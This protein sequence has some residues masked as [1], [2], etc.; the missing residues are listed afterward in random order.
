MWHNGQTVVTGPVNTGYPRRADRDWRLRRL[1]APDRDDD[2]RHEPGRHALQRS[3]NP[4]GQ[5]LQRRRRPARF[6]PRFLRLPAEPRLRR[7]AISPKPT[8]CGR[9][10]RSERSSTSASSAPDRHRG[11]DAGRSA[12]AA[13]LLHC[14]EDRYLQTAI[15]VERVGCRRSAALSAAVAERRSTALERDLRARACA[16]KTIHAYA[17]DCTQLACWASAHARRARSSSTSGRCDDSWPG[18][19]QDGTGARSTIARKLAAVRALFGVQVAS[20]ERE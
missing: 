16:A 15:A 10:R 5:L 18:S 1:R 9:T 14:D 19:P 7:D 13:N 4:M 3:R 12:W 8:R 6:H 17:I 2:V 20:G 11:G